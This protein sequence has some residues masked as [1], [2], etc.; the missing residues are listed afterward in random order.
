[1]GGAFIGRLQSTLE[2]LLKVDLHGLRGLGTGGHAI[3]RRGRTRGRVVK[4]LLHFNGGGARRM[5]F[6]AV[7]RG[8]LTRNVANHFGVRRNLLAVRQTR[9]G[10][11][12]FDCDATANHSL[13]DTATNLSFSARVF[14]VDF[15]SNIGIDAS[16][17]SRSS[18]VVH[19]NVRPGAIIPRSSVQG[20][21]FEGKFVDMRLNK[22]RGGGSTWSGMV[23]LWRGTLGGTKRS[24]RVRAK[25]ELLE[26]K[27]VLK[28]RFIICV[29]AYNR[30]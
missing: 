16:A 13:A 5:R 30:P 26:G 11:G 14:E 19:M 7:G 1:M 22:E 8:G 10:I 6:V 27:P 17:M 4:F 3:R 12:R 18:A 29:R 24:C 9:M 21:L 28:P 2:I 20:N 15:L 25:E 23:K